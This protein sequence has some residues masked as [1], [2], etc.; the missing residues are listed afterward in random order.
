[1]SWY[2]RKV[3]RPQ[4]H[5]I[6]QPG[7]IESKF[8]DV[9]IALR[10][11]FISES[12]IEELE[13]RFEKSKGEKGKNALYKAGK[14]FGWK[15]AKSSGFPQVN[16]VSEKR[17][18]E[19]SDFF[20]SYIQVL[21][22]SKID[23]DV[24]LDEERFSMR[25]KEYSVCRNNGRGHVLSAGVV[26]GVV[27][28]LFDDM[29][30]EASKPSCQGRGD[31]ECEVICTTPD[32]LSDNEYSASIDDMEVD[33]KYPEVNR[34]RKPEFA[35]NSMKDLLDKDIFQYK[36][37]ILSFE[38][39][40]YIP[41]E[42]S[43]IYLLEEELEELDKNLVFKTVYKN[44][45]NISQDRD[46]SFLMDYLPALG[47]GDLKP[48]KKGRKIHVNYYPWTELAEYSSFSVFRGLTSGIVS[49]IKEEEICFDSWETN[50]SGKGFTM[51]LKNSD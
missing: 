10:E 35:S 51:T 43:L 18:R 19:F 14:Q 39:E 6:G 23:Y 3:L 9:E 7:F 36:K 16:K 44:G 13:N 31:E 33:S 27:A 21:Y 29:S 24:S 37:G 17:F 50:L 45:E 25:M 42:I 1:M 4:I 47:W 22:A 15:Y 40:R 34:V 8:K 41:V 11:L 5:N 49:G 28:Y 20:V 48:L 32:N 46:I 38:S 30:I 26:A 2:I 12:L